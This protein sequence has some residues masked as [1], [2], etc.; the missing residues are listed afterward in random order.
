MNDALRSYSDFGKKL[1]KEV[2][3]NLAINLEKLDIPSYNQVILNMIQDELDNS[4]YKE[5]METIKEP[6]GNYWHK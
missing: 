5:G 4:I 6:T 3:T 1:K 2:E